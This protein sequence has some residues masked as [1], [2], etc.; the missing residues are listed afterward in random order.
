MTTL[1][2]DTSCSAK[3]STLSQGLHQ[4]TS[5]CGFAVW[6]CCDGGCGGRLHVSESPI[7]RRVFL[8]LFPLVFLETSSKNPVFLET[9]SK[10]LE[11]S[12]WLKIF[13]DLASGRV[14]EATSGKVR[15]EVLRRLF[16]KVLREVRGRSFGKAVRDEVRQAPGVVPVPIVTHAQ[17][18]RGGRGRVQS[19]HRQWSEPGRES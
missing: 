10:I 2:K 3:L 8:R 13:E 12:S 1:S 4:R 11:A 15:E 9:R 19:T 7:F 5:V 14:R 17:S 6:V 16:W 18:L